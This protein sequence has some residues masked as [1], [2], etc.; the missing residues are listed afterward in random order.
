MALVAAEEDGDRML[1]VKELSTRTRTAKK[2]KK[3]KR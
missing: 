3:E 2:K 1:V